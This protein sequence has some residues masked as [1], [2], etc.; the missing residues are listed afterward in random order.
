MW[1]DLLTVAIALPTLLDLQVERDAETTSYEYSILAR[2]DSG[3]FVPTMFFIRSCTRSGLAS[4]T[5]SAQHHT[6]FDV[7][8]CHARCS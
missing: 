2:L 1:Q 5:G 8:R 6:V 3:D 7:S 4:L